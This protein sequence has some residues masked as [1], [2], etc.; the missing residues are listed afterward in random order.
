MAMLFEQVVVI[1]EA[2]PWFLLRCGVQGAL[3]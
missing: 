3:P 1:N 2:L